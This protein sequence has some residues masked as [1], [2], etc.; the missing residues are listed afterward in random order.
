M[1]S[2]VEK[3]IVSDNVESNLKAMTLAYLQ[4]VSEADTEAIKNLTKKQ[5]CT[6][7]L[8]WIAEIKSKGEYLSLP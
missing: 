6:K 2:Y 5:L 8:A 4:A 3:S 7:S 1:E